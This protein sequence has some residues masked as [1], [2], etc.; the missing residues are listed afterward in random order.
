M[1]IFIESLWFHTKWYHF[2]LLIVLFP[3]S[4][5]WGVIMALRRFFSKERD[6]G[7]PIISV[8][9]LVVGGTGKTPFLIELLSKHPKAFVISRG[10]GR[11]S[12]GYF[13]VSQGGEILVGVDTSADEPMLIAQS[14]K[15]CS[16]IVSEDRKFGIQKAKELGAKIIFLDD[17]FNQVGVKKFSIL[18]QFQNRVNMLPLPAGPYRELPFFERS[19]DLIVN[20]GVDFAR[21]VDFENLGKKMVLVTA[22]SNPA[23]LDEFLPKDVVAKYYFEDHSYFDEDSLQDIL[24]KEG[25]DRLLVTQKD[26]VK[27]VDFKLP[28]AIIKLKLEI[29]NYIFDAIDNYIK[30]YES[31]R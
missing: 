28:L 9:N 11:Q 2:P 17:G 12:R 10:Y 21:L 7:I 27:M 19:A 6:F 1:H 4:F 16:V 29:K 15:E 14:V 25:A 13:L 30:G 31:E 8:G 24:E 3:L 20:E 22:I 23:R 18:L 26:L 5:L